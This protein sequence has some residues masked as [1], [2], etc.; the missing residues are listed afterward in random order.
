MSRS[1][2]SIKPVQPQ[3]KE[4]RVHRLLWGPVI[5]V[6]IVEIEADEHF[7]LSQCV[8]QLAPQWVIPVPGAANFEC[9][10]PS[11]QLARP[12]DTRTFWRSLPRQLP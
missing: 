1:I 4:L 7:I 5:V 9:P 2:A 8:S 11:F 12:T 3:D 10:A 6:A